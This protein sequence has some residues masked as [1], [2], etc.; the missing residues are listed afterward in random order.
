MSL[1]KK[2]KFKMSLTFV[3]GIFFVVLLS[4]T[5]VANAQFLDSIKT[6]FHHNPK[7][8]LRGELRNSFITTALARVIALKIGLD[9]NKTVKVG[10]GYNVLYT[11]VYK[12]GADGPVPKK[13]L[14][15]N[16]ISPYMVYTYYRKGN[17]ELSIPV[18]FGFGTSDY[19]DVD[20]SMIGMTGN[21]VVLYEPYMSAQYRLLRYIGLGVGMGYRI[22]LVG[23]KSIGQNFNSPIY[24]FKAK[25]FFGDLFRDLKKLNGSN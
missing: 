7:L 24:V 23:N 4:A 22:L 3:K 13:K 12:G 25:I 11:E 20:K 1:L 5:T 18:Q 9:F 8:D 6:S 21:P 14:R 17:W 10:F 15:L 19:V 2:I 16:Y